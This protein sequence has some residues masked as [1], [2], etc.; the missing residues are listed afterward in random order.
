MNLRNIQTSKLI[1]GNLD[2]ST[3]LGGAARSHK[4]KLRDRLPP[5]GNRKRHS[6]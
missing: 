3:K 6:M 2:F 1:S 4:I 5:S